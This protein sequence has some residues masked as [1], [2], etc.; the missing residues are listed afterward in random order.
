MEVEVPKDVF[1]RI[2]NMR[3]DDL[4]RF[5]YERVVSLKRYLEMNDEEALLRRKMEIEDRIRKMKNEIAELT[6]FCE[7]A[8][9]DQERMSIWMDELDM[10]NRNL[11][12]E[13]RGNG[14]Y[15]QGG[16]I[17]KEKVQD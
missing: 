12:E 1:E 2:R 8:R 16:K 11:L 17:K 13:M 9:R 15:L 4:N 14:D 10:E 6:E 3:E 5:I 7:R